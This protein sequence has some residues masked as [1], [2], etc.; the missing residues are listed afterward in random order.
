MDSDSDSCSIKIL[1]VCAGNICRS[2]MAEFLFKD[3]I[4]KNNLQ[5][6]FLINSAATTSEQIGKDIA[7][8]TKIE[9]DKRNIPYQK[10]KA[11]K[12][13]KEDYNNYDYIIGMDQK[14]ID[15]IFKIIKKDTKRKVYKLLD[16]SNNPRDIIDPIYTNDFNRTYLEI[17]EGCDALFKFLMSNKH[18]QL[19]SA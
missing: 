8:G 17:K 11:V 14:I 16:F 15:G 7:E 1:F 2:P 13:L 4:K 5:N 12:L 3:I 18:T 10:R 6:N 19:Y 9:L